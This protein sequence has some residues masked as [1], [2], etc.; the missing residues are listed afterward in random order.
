VKT[1]NIQ[2]KVGIV[3]EADGRITCAVAQSLKDEFFTFISHRAQCSAPIFDSSGNAPHLCWVM[4]LTATKAEFLE[5]CAD[6][7]AKHPAKFFE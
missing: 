7:A 3:S 2:D 4:T 1:P 6:F 5:L